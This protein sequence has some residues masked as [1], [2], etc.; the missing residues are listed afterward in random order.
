MLSFDLTGERRQDEI[1]NI[2]V[3]CRDE[4]IHWAGA[5]GAAASPIP[6]TEDEG[7]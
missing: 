6:P 5:P 2:D 7:E 3:R 1:Q 4:L